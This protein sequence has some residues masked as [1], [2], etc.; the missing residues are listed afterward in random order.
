LNEWYISV[1]D[2]IV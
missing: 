1:F 2:P